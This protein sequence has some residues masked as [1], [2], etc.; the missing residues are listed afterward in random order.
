M[1]NIRCPA[2]LVAA[3]LFLSVAFIADR[4]A[5]AQTTNNGSD[6]KRIQVLQIV[7]AGSAK[8]H[9]TK[10]ANSSAATPKKKVA[11][12]NTI[13]QIRLTAPD[14]TPTNTNP[15]AES[16][17]PVDAST[18]PA[19]DN[20][21]R[22]SS[23]QTDVL[24]FGDRAVVF[25]SF[26]GDESNIGLTRNDL[27]RVTQIPAIARPV[28]ETSALPNVDLV[29]QVDGGSSPM[30]QVSATLSGVM[31]AGGFCWYLISHSRFRRLL[32]Q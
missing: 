2:D 13:K 9:S 23:Q 32:W 29:R 17:L 24:A 11:A 10:K 22:S 20:I 7:E 14:P 18:T 4:T 15:Q 8:A 1:R 25:A 16:A 19:H 26:T 5:Q 30:P 12:R 6:G 27:L 28:T 31:L 3:T 21:E